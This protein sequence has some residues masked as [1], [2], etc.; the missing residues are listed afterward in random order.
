VGEVSDLTHPAVE[1]T[2]QALGVRTQE[3]AVIQER[4]K[5][6]FEKMAKS[7]RK[8]IERIPRSLPEG[9]VLVHSTV[10][11]ARPIGK[12]GSRMWV[13]NIDD[14]IEL[15]ACGREWWS[16]LP[17]Y[18][19]VEEV[20]QMIDDSRR[21]ASDH[22]IRQAILAAKQHA[23]MK[24]IQQRMWAESNAPKKFVPRWARNRR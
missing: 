3:L 17:H 8:N 13:Q 19:P 24:S 15:C 1:A 18:R 5:V 9:R 7:D 10:R 23:E 20:S 16:H 4:A 11:L 2:G 12:N 14:T 22:E 21:D 6:Y